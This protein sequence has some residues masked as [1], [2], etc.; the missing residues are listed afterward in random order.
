MTQFLV[1]RG[2][3]PEAPSGYVIVP[4]RAVQPYVAA[5]IA[6]IFPGVDREEFWA[7]DAREGEA[8]HDFINTS[9]EAVVLEGADLETTAFA[10][11]IRG[12]GALG[13][14][15][16]CWWAGAEDALPVLEDVDAFLACAREGMERWEV[17]AILRPPRPSLLERAT[18]RERHRSIPSSSATPHEAA[19][20]G[21]EMV[22]P[23]RQNVTRR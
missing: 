1:G 11:W 10:R 8:G 6:T 12:C 3:R 20:P 9:F 16:I 21:G 22:S 19:A 5:T 15:V 2:P 23:N 7:L 14:E 13:T 4:L 18:T 17:N